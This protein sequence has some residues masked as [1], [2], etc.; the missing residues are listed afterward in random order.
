MAELREV[1]AGLG[2][3]DVRT[4]LQSGNA[5]FTTDDADPRARLERAVAGHFGFEVSCLVRTAGELRAVAA[6]CPYPAAE[7]D[8]AKLLVVFLEEAPPEGHFD[9]VDAAAFAP[10]T[11][12]H[13]GSAVYCYFPDG[14][15]RSRLPA[16]LESLRPKVTATSRNWRTVQRLIELAG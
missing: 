7:L 2:W 12:H 3:S 14:M 16:A 4:Y 15:G 6:A 5:V 11:F 1:M 10:D 9:S 13:A 8:P